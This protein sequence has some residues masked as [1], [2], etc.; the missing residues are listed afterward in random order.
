MKKK[1]MLTAGILLLAFTFATPAVPPNQEQPKKSEGR[2]VI[3][4]L[5]KK[6]D[7]AFL[8]SEEI[9]DALAIISDAA[10][11]MR[12]QPKIGSQ[13]EFLLRN[14]DPAVKQAALKAIGKL[15]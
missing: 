13:V 11:E 14:P 10:D 15:G 8:T 5:A 6:I 3:K 2:E 7:K 4:G 12:W 9:I 1:L